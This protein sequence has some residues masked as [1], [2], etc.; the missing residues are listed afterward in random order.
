[1]VLS[2]SAVDATSTADKHHKCL[3][4]GFCHCSVEGSVLWSLRNKILKV[5]KEAF[6]RPRAEEFQKLMSGLC[7]LR[8]QGTAPPKATS[9]WAMLADELLDS[10]VKTDELSAG[11]YW[12]H[13]GLLY[14]P[15]C[16]GSS[17]MRLPI[18]LPRYSAF[19]N[20]ASSLRWRSSCRGSTR[21]AG[22]TLTSL[23][24]YRPPDQWS[25]WIPVGA[26]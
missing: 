1:M 16:N 18:S 9:E 26:G 17:E 25:G 20:M 8:L 19:N 22:G 14:V 6:P 21:D 23:R 5:M 2:P 7:V 24:W 15:Q 3:K 4:A 12:M 13:V 11:V 10:E